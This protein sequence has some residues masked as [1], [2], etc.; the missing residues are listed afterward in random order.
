MWRNGSWRRKGWEVTLAILV[1]MGPDLKEVNIAGHSHD[2]NGRNRTKG[3]K[4]AGCQGICCL[5]MCIP[6]SFL[7]HSPNMIILIV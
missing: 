7:Q 5:F 1:A 4:P 6:Y 2:P 3:K